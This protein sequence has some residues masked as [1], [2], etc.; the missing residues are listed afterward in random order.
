MRLVLIEKKRYTV[1]ENK[2]CIAVFELEEDVPL[3]KDQIEELR[4]AD[5]KELA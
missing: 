1:Y 5:I 4:L 3:D 2:Q